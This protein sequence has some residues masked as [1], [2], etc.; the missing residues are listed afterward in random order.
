MGMPQDD[1]PPLGGTF[2]SHME[3]ECPTSVDILSMSRG[4]LGR[5]LR[6]E[7]RCN[8]LLDLVDRHPVNGPEDNEPGWVLPEVGENGVCEENPLVR[9][10]D[11][12]LSARGVEAS[13]RSRCREVASLLNRNGYLECSD[14]RLC[15]RLHSSQEECRLVVETI[16]SLDPAGIGAR[17]LKECLLLQAGRYCP[18]DRTLLRIIEEHLDLG[19]ENKARLL[20]LSME[21]N[22]SDISGSLAVLR[23]LSIRPVQALP[24]GM[25]RPAPEADVLVKVIRDRFQ[26]VLNEAQVPIPMM[27]NYYQMILRVEQEDD[28]LREYLNRNLTRTLGIIKSYENRNETLRRIVEIL[29]QEQPYLTDPRAQKKRLTMTE[30]AGL[31]GCSVSTVS[32]AVKGKYMETP[33]GV[34][35]FKKIFSYRRQNAE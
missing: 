14:E 9:F 22:I 17:S 6:Q 30:M 23:T 11:S 13:L 32:R 31:I 16:Q 34:F 20:A 15:E 2:Q 26:V 29:L 28:R 27:S 25:L 24:A 5:F 18:E 21:V 7:S 1:H 19:L 8:T 12:Q 4:E 10:V 35:S 3:S 33:C